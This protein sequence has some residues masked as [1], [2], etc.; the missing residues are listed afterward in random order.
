[1]STPLLGGWPALLRSRSDSHA[2][3][4]SFLLAGKRILTLSV[5]LGL[6]LVTLGCD[7]KRASSSM[8]P[9]PAGNTGPGG[10]YQIDLFKAD[11]REGTAI[12]ILV[13]T[14][15]SMAQAVKDRD[16][17]MRPKNQIAGDALRHI[18]QH[19]A[20]WKK[21]HP[22][23]NLQMALYNFSSSVSEVLPMGEFDQGK[24]QAALDRIPKPNSGTAIGTALEA[25]FKALYRSGCTRK[26]VLCVT[27]GENTVGP[28][29]D[30]IARHLHARTG[31]EVELDF[32]A[33]DTSARQFKFLSE[34]N[35]H[36]VEASDGARLQAE[37]QKIYQERI[38]VE[39][40]E[41]S[42]K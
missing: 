15:G 25:A 6:G 29:P 12:V 32:V 42:P 22:K 28:S 34:V 2:P 4:A 31:G 21:G 1:M 39:K 17:K 13:D 9:K 40:E 41:P 36:V 33:F 18:I 10:T 26:F 8:A 5:A 27:D 7:G 14:S 3:T 30:W 38:L 19:T 23:A 35:G 24:A 16:G 20:D 11:P 37:M